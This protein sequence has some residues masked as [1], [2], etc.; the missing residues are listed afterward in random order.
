MTTNTNINTN[1]N[2]NASSDNQAAIYTRTKL[3]LS[4]VHMTLELVLLGIG[5]F[6][7]S[8]PLYQLLS[9]LIQ[10]EY[11]LLLA[12]FTGFGALLSVFL[13]PLEFYQSYIVEHKFGLSNQTITSWFIEE[14]KSL[15]VS[16]IIGLPLVLLF[17]YFIKA[18]PLWWLY[19]AIV[20]FVVAIMLAK[21]AP[22][23]I[24][25]LFYKFTPI[26][27]EELKNTLTQLMNKHGLRVSGIFVFNMSKDTKK[28]NAAFTGLGKT[29]R[30]ILSDTMLNEFSL[31]E[32]KTVFAHELGHYVHKHIV[33]NIML[34]GIIIIVLFYVCSYLY[35]ITLHSAGYSHRYD[36][37]A[38]PILAFYLSVLSLLL[39]PLLNTL[40]RYYE[41][42]A[43]KYA[44][45]ITDDPESFISTMEKLAAMNLSQKEQHPVI[46]FFL[47]SH[48]TIAKRIALAKNYRLISA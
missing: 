39:M 2:T 34:S 31:S 37:Q 30:I 29:R 36:I 11:L 35:E 10:N 17:Y 23:I 42:Q 18:T 16:A 28:A 44:L 20:V 24:F 5:A 14:L 26:D 21:I 13:F 43:D 12:F 27:N 22:V 3:K 45:K 19:F 1:T 6:T 33:K 4:I 47:Y 9:P 15:L 40:S 7:I 32:I 48:P 8:E 25:P 41:K 46:E 38:M